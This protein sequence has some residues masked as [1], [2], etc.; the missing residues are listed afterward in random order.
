[1]NELSM[2]NDTREGASVIRW[3]YNP[4]YYIAGGKA[5]AV[6]I[7]VMLITGYLA[8]LGKV[9]FDGLLDFHFGGMATPLWLNISEI[10][11]SWLLLSILLLFFGRILSKSRIRFIDVFGT[12]ALARFPYFL[13]SIV[14]LLLPG[15]SR[16]N[17]ELMQV[18]LAKPP[19]FPAFSFDMAALFFLVFFAILMTIW[20]IILMYRAF[21]V[22][23][24]VSGKSAISL[25]IVALIVVEILSLFAIRLG[26]QSAAAQPENV[27]AQASESVDLSSRASEFV[28]FLSDENYESAVNMFD[29]TMTSAMPEKKLEEVWQ[30]LLSQVGS[31]QSREETQKKEI[32]GYDVYIIPCHFERASLKTQIAFDKQGKIAGLYFL[33]P[34]EDP[35]I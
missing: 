26:L 23:C 11:V 25:F 2:A 13:I 8:F 28:A 32:P 20:M 24:N 10:L 35:G 19:A 12:Q 22:S 6:G 34:I 16:F 18:L 4:F 5:L 9:R 17:Q 21:S 27:L 7:I 3:L 29:E 15:A 31:F 1:M 30:S 33:P 14:V